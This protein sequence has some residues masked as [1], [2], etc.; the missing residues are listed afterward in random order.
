MASSDSG[1]VLTAIKQTKDAL[2]NMNSSLKSLQDAST[3]LSTNL[4]SVR[5]SIE[6]SLNSSDCASD[7]ASKICDSIRPG[8]SSLG[9]NHDSSQVSGCEHAT[10]RRTRES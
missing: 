9:S 10:A 5:N 8:L 3:Q 4:T 1:C 2:Q 7:P 6:N